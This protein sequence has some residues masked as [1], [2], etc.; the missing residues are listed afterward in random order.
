M[1][2]IFIF[3]WGNGMT[4]LVIVYWL[5]KNLMLL[6]PKEPKQGGLVLDILGF[7]FLFFQYITHY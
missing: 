4:L 1:N 5:W 6:F 7:S 2:A 3:V